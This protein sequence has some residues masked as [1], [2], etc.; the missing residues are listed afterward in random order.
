MGCSKSKYLVNNKELIKTK[1]QEKN[2]RIDQVANN[3]IPIPEIY[4]EKLYNSIVRINFTTQEKN[5]I[6]TGFFLKLNINNNNRN[7]L[8]TC[9]HIIEEKDVE[10]NIIITLYYGKLKEE[11]SF[12]I[13][14]DRNERYIK[15]FDKPIDVTLVEII[16]E[17][18]INEEKYLF[19]DLNYNNRYNLYINNFFYLAGYPQNF[20]IKAGRSIS[21]GKILKILDNFE[22]EHNID[23][24]I[25]NSGSP[26][27]IANSNKLLV[28]GIHKEGNI[29]ESINYGTFI[30]Y[31]LDI[32]ENEKN[33]KNK[34]LGNLS[35][36]MNNVDIKE[37]IVNIN[38]KEEKLEK[39][40]NKEGEK[41]EEKIY[42]V[43]V[44]LIPP[45]C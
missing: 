22:F 20:L 25:G 45:P 29:I 42:T 13:K 16:E 32:L 8:V 39:E 12:N 10:E 23:T 11:K 37:Q 30:G 31:I 38:K 21:S 34:K 19:A 2:G 40:V 43:S 24:Y 28:V 4:S 26:I 36:S 35:K 27:C 1:V 41:E 33:E 5:S 17:D 7:F 6:G 18:K 9:Y 44:T 3:A 14:L 15:C